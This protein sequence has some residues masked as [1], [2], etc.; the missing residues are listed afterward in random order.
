MSTLPRHGPRDPEDADR[1]DPAVDAARTDRTLPELLGQAGAHEEE[2]SN[3]VWLAGL[4]TV[5][6]FLALVALVV[7]RL[8]PA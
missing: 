7:S 5:L 4:V 2:R 1:P 8:S 6:A 3:L